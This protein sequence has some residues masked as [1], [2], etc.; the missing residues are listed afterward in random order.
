M[1]VV[2]KEEGR[3]VEGPLKGEEREE[4]VLKEEEGR[5][6]DKEGKERRVAMLM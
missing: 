6:D 3:E 5:H 2:W 1:R 4:G